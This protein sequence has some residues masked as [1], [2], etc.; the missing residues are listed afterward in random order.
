M[1]RVSCLIFLH[2]SGIWLNEVKSFQKKLCCFA[3]MYALMM[4]KEVFL[5]VVLLTESLFEHYNKINLITVI[6]TWSEIQC[7][8]MSRQSSENK[9]LQGC[10]LNEEF[11]WKAK[12]TTML[13]RVWTVS[14]HP[15]L[16]CRL[17]WNGLAETESL[18]HYVMLVKKQLW[19]LP[20]SSSLFSFMKVIWFALARRFFDCFCTVVAYGK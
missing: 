18:Q 9:Q 11:L 14:N 5:G 10:Q 15:L 8:S 7:G 6:L 1:L 16:C 13:L 2:S 4:C 17:W 12:Q 19:L 3:L 20:T